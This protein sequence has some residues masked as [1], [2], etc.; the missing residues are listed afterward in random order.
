[1]LHSSEDLNRIYQAVD[2][3][4]TSSA[5]TEISIFK[6]WP[7]H[8]TKEQLELTLKTSDDIVALHKDEKVLMTGTLSELI[9]K[10]CGYI[11]LHDGK[12]PQKPVAWIG[13][14]AIVAALD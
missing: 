11:M 9:F 3:Y 5:T 6:D 4:F 10:S 7:K 13:H 1:M 2:N 14:D 8:S 12:N